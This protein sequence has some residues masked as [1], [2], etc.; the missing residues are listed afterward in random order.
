MYMYMKEFSTLKQSQDTIQYFLSD[1]SNY[2]RLTCI[3][4]FKTE[5]I[6]YAFTLDIAGKQG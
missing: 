6:S 4:I 1:I 2:S 3:Y 5:C